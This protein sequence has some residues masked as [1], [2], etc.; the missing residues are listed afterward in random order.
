MKQLLVALAVVCLLAA[1]A[2]AEDT[3]VGRVKT[4]APEA[5]ILRGDQTLPAEAGA[6]VFAAD[7]LLTGPG[8]SLG[9]VFKDGA[10]LSLGPKSEFVID[11]YVFVPL[12]KQISFVSRMQRG[13]ATYLSGAM[14]RISPESV[15]FQTPMA[16]LGLRGTK[17]LIK[18]Q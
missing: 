16:Q 3:P 4:M 1:T 7:T 12:E 18:V 14:G 13:T 15:K 17:I 10:V 2:W 9:V 5:S 11:Q 8:G 6:P